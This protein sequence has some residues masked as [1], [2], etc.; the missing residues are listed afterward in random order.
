MNGDPSRTGDGF[1]RFSLCAD[2]TNNKSMIFGNLS[3][4]HKDLFLVLGC[5]H[6]CSHAC[7]RKREFA[8]SPGE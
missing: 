3:G 5:M 2:V 6:C 7:P 4:V 8:V 1:G